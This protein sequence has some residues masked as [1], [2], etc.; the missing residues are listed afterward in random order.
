MLAHFLLALSQCCTPPLSSSPQLSCGTLLLLMHRVRLDTPEHKASPPQNASL[1][2][3]EQWV[4]PSVPR[5]FQKEI[6]FVLGNAILPAC[7]QFVIPA[8]Y[9]MLLLRMME[10]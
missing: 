6:R 10:L 3:L 5:V 4:H 8:E 7:P 2:G 1:L 9:G